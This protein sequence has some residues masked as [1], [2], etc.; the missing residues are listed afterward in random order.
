MRTTSFVSL[1]AVCIFYH[2]NP[3]VSG[4]ENADAEREKVHSHGASAT[5][6]NMTLLLRSKS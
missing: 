2:I 6:S 4:I 5:A 1:V 3:S